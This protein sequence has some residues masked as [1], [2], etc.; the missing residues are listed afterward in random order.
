MNKEI[1]LKELAEKLYADTVY[2]LDYDLDGLVFS[3]KIGDYLIKTNSILK[4]LT[5]ENFSI[6]VAIYLERIQQRYDAI[7]YDVRRYK[8]SDAKI[9]KIMLIGLDDEL[10]E[11]QSLKEWIKAEFTYEYIT[12][13][14]VTE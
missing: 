13:Y 6:V 7:L 5:K 12:A 3:S 2:M 10:K 8:A 11:I 14:K 9:D 4:A 1:N